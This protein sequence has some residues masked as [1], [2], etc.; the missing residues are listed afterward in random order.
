MGRRTI[1]VTGV[2]R[3]IGAAIAA[4]CSV[5]GYEV[6]GLSRTKPDDF[7]GIHHA[8]DLGEKDA[9]AA[10][11]DIAQRH[12]PCRLVANAGIVTPGPVETA[13]DDDFERTMRINVQSILWAVQ[14]MLPAMRSERFGRIVTLGS[15]AALGKRERAIYSASKAAVVGLTRTLA[16]ELAAHEVTVNCV[17]PG[18][19]ETEMFKIDQPVGS[20]KRERLMAGVPL[21]RVGSTDD[22]AHSVSHFLADEAGYV[23]GQVLHVCGGLSVGGS[24]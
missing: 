15:R 9:K 4:R 5:D 24:A 16:L 18:P 1:L 23:T 11:A 19:I 6:V 17:A 14:A 12:A 21:G 8:V 7:D 3:G 22:I 20:E 10:L 2:S 13:E